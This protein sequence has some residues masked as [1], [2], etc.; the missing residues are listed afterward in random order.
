M[1][2]PGIPTG[3]SSSANSPSGMRVGAFGQGNA[4]ITGI[5]VGSKYGSPQDGSRQAYIGTH[6]N[7]P[8]GPPIWEWDKYDF[9]YNSYFELGGFYDGSALAKSVVEW[10]DQYYERRR[11]AYYENYLR[12]IIDATYVPVFTLEVERKTMINGKEDEDGKGAPL[13][14]AFQENC[15]N[16]GTKIEDF[17]KKIVR[18]AR[19]LGV[20]FIV[21]DN[22]PVIPELREDAIKNRKLPFVSMRLPQQVEVQL[23]KLDDFDRIE[24]IVF[25]EKP[26]N[27]EDRWKK[28]TTYHS[29]KLTKDK[30]G[31]W[32]EVPNTLVEHKLGKVPVIP[33]SPN[34][35]EDGTILPH[36]AF[37]SLARCN[38]ALFNICSSQMRLLRSQMFAILC[39]SKVEGGLSVSPTGGIDMP[40]NNT[41]TG[42]TYE[43]P[44]YLSPPTGP[45]E[46]ITQTIQNI[47]EELYRL[48]G[49]ES[50]QGVREVA[51]GL[52]KSFDFAAKESVLIESAKMARRA[53][54]KMAEHTML[55]TGEVFDYEAGYA[56]EFK[57]SNAGDKLDRDGKYL[58]FVQGVSTPYNPPVGNILKQLT[59]QTFE[60]KEETLR[61]INE[62]IDKNT[63]EEAQKE[64]PQTPEELA[65]IRDA[66]NND[67]V[68]NFLRDKNKTPN[69]S[70]GFKKKVA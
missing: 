4:P 61:K 52:A 34:E 56:T 22:F 1:A 58:E 44:F 62:W 12:P 46:G 60:G 35:C 63:S 57:P 13:W 6:Q 14:H 39:A 11:V 64:T 8:P 40:A 69:N 47:R 55:Y 51:S 30:N 54:E 16:R 24:E 49:Q 23:L 20:A 5:L 26:E 15:D 50:V 38:W 19:L 28:W 68:V 37:Y 32:I 59:G 67:S 43:R 27:G 33:I 25:R 42:E 53:E 70:I 17:T 18:H 65:A 7:S 66:G 31:D 29:V 3:L 9:M 36:P 21:M 41:T 45:Y 2:D 48:A 10:D